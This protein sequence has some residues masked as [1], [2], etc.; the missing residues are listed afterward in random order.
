MLGPLAVTV[1]R[2]EPGDYRA[3]HETMR[4]PR[5]VALTMQLPYESLETW[6]KRLSEPLEGFYLLLACRETE[7]G[8]DVVGNLGLHT[9]PTRP[10]RRHVGTLGMAV[11][12]DVQGRGVGTALMR[13]ALEL[14]DGW[15]GLTRLELEVYTDNEAAIRLYQN[16]GFETEGTLRRYALRS[17]VF[18]DAYMMARLL[19]RSS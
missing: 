17:G 13:S 16:F 12:D 11:R 3:V 5:V 2:A 9:F 19:P 1:R 14:A 8:E 7:A 6:R 10:R 4:G 15:L 18:V